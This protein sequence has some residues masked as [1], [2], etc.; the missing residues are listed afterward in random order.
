MIDKDNISQ[1]SEALISLLI[2]AQISKRVKIKESIYEEEL[3]KM[4]NKIPDE[5]LK[6]LVLLDPDY[7]LK[8]KE[9]CYKR[10]QNNF[11]WSIVSK[12]LGDL[13]H[14]IQKIHS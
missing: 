14:Q 13:F 10:V 12:K 11:R 9:N 1:F 2:L 7:Y 5:I 3:L 8:I 4:V 6:A